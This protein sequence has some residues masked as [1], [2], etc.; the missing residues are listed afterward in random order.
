[1]Y[2]LLNDNRKYILYSFVLLIVISLLFWKCRFGYPKFDEAFYLA[3]TKRFINGDRFLVDDWYGAQLFSLFLIP[4]V[5]LYEFFN[6]GTEGIFLFIRYSYTTIKV[7]SFFCIMYFLR[8]LVGINKAF[9]AA[10]FYLIL[11][12]YGM[13]VISYNT[14]AITGI[15]ISLLLLLNTEDSFLCWVKR[16]FSGC[17]LSIAVLSIPYLLLFYIIYLVA[18]FCISLSRLKNNSNLKLYSFKN[19]IGLTFGASICCISFFCLII[20]QS[21]LQ[22]VLTTIPYIILGDNTHEFKSFYHLTVAYFVRILWGNERNILLLIVYTLIASVC[23]YSLFDRKKKKKQNIYI[24]LAGCLGILLL[25]VYIFTENYINHYIFLPNI[26]ALMIICFMREQIIQIRGYIFYSLFVP[27]VIVTYLE[28]VSSN[29]GFYCISYFS[30]ISAISSI[31]IILDS[32]QINKSKTSLILFLLFTF[33]SIFY[34]RITYIFCEDLKINQLNSI[35]SSGPAKKL[36]VSIDDNKRYENMILDTKLIR[37][38]SDMTYVLYFGDLVFYVLAN[39]KL[40]SYSPIQ[41]SKD[42]NLLY[43]YYKR[44]EY[45]KPTVI[46]IE[47]DYPK[48]KTISNELSKKLDLKI[49]YNK[50]GFLLMK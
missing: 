36:H 19:L 7:I 30:C 42:N 31:I 47:Y 5:K 27:G 40:A 35:V 4:F 11:A 29:T 1:M 14:L 3:E 26:V 2:S 50:F 9:F 32:I 45:K 41:Y 10:L 46:Y 22:E 48:A 25:L 6:D 18:T 24:S 44:F 38:M 15:L 33:L 12:G 28:Y 8:S 43:S 37:E 13:M 34:A 16:F 49:Y 20:S 39:Q 21:D 23:L 17:F